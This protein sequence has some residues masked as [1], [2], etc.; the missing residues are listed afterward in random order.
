MLGAS[1]ALSM[2]QWGVNAG[3]TSSQCRLVCAQTVRH[4]CWGQLRTG[5]FPALPVPSLPQPGRANTAGLSQ[6]RA[7][8]HKG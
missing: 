5:L 7:L 2:G 6:I 4:C 1:R 3:E 8:R